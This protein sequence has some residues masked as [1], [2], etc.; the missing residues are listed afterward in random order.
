MGNDYAACKRLF[1]ATRLNRKEVIIMLKGSGLLDHLLVLGP[2]FKEIF[3]KDL[4]VWISDTDNILGYFPGAKFDVGSDGILSADDPM[5]IAMQKR[6]PMQTNMPAGIAGIPFKEIDNPILDENDNVVGCIT[7]GISLD[8]ET[9]VVNVA[10]SIDE[11]VENINATIMEF[12][13]SAENIKNSEAVLRENINGVNELTKQ[14]N[15]VL[16][17]TK[18]IADQTNLLG[19]NASIEAARAGSFGAGFGIVA[20]EIC[21]LSV[22]SMN[23][24]RKIEALLIQI[25]E[26]N[27]MTLECSDSAIGATKE[28]DAE[29]KR[30]KEKI[31]ELKSISDQLMAISK[32]I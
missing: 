23:V 26:A 22:E 5:R 7:F 9:K 25:N 16:S 12:A 6:Q 18:R 28:Q 32:E 10:Q 20:D 3:G 30:T 13:E 27:R 21:K 8:Q 14:I 17:F 4:V 15:K 24:A 11:A 31:I 29:I 1:I 19:L 2:Y